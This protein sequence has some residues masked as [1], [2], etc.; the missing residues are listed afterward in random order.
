MF[1][2]SSFSASLLLVKKSG[3]YTPLKV[4]L[5]ISDKFFDL[6]INNNSV[7]HS[8]IPNSAAKFSIGIP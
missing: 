6:L 7:Y 3:D 5:I 4:F 2:G 8:V 1:G